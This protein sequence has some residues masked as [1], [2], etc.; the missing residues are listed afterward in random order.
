[1]SN[2]NYKYNND[3]KIVQLSCEYFWGYQVY[4]DITQFND[5]SQICS[6]IVRCLRKELHKL[7]LKT[8]WEKLE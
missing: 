5:Y 8:L 3:I 2:L 4:L 1:M 6:F 7:K